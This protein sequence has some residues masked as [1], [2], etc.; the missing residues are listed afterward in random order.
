M[1]EET[2]PIEPAAPDHAGEKEIEKLRRTNNEILERL[3]VAE[4]E[5]QRLRADLALKPAEEKKEEQKK[6]FAEILGYFKRKG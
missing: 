2:K 6:T 1:E 5:V 4:D 3:R